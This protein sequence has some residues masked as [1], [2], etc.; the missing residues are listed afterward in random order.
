MK[1]LTQNTIKCLLAAALFAAIQSDALAKGKPVKSNPSPEEPPTEEPTPS[2]SSLTGK[3][4]AEVA[5][6]GLYKVTAAQIAATLGGSENEAAT[7][8]VDGKVRVSSM[9]SDVAWLKANDSVYFYGEEIG[10]MY[11]GNNVYW[12]ELGV[13]GPQMAADKARAPRKQGILCR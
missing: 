3:I 4:R 9:G 13:S 10:G 11:G 2:E 1:N 8:I 6:S 5:T 7:A 12:L